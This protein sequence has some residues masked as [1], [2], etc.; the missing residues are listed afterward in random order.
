MW[1]ILMAKNFDAK[2]KAWRE[3]LNS[4]CITFFPIQAQQ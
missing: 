1:R 4:D 2:D 3:T